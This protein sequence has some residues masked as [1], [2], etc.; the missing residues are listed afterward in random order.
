MSPAELLREPLHV[1]SG[2]L[3]ESG[4]LGLPAGEGRWHI[5]FGGRQRPLLMPVGKYELQKR[6][7]PYFIGGRL[8]TLYAMGLL[9]LNALVPA[10]GLLPEF[11]AR[12]LKD[13]V[14]QE[15]QQRSDGMVIGPW[16]AIQIGT[17]GPHQKA[18]ALFLSENGEGLALAKI[19]LAASADSMVVAE[20]SWLRDLEGMD[21]LAGQV[22]RL[23]A[24]GAVGN[25]RRYLVSSVAP[26]TQVT[27]DFTSAH[28][29]FLAR[30]GRARREIMRFDSSPCCES[31]VRMLAEITP[32][33]MRDE[34]A[35]LRDALC[36]CRKSLR[37][38]QGPFVLSQGDFAWWN[39]RV[40]PRG[41][42]VFDW[43]CAQHGANPLADLFHYHLIRR[44][45]AGRSVSKS[46]LGAVVQRAQVFAHQH[47]PE[48]EWCASRVSALVL[49]YVLD[50]FFR[51]SRAIGGI[52]RKEHVM[53]GYWSLIERRSTW[54][55]A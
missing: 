34:A 8:R 14:Q 50:V 41:I 22:P 47:Y 20:A 51:Y 6:G 4:S 54:L 7:L 3:A 35:R 25:G 17:K 43:E 9:K 10:F 21:G 28:A 30:L 1:I 36:D 48:S 37:D 52:D 44:A 40:H 27:T 13:T 11:E 46:Y 2:V 18:S 45:A 53:R 5:L 33:L 42:F 23:L 32:A 49:A 55:T 38:Y 19:A 24:E 15:C 29:G 26:S 31:L 16:V 39:I 12:R